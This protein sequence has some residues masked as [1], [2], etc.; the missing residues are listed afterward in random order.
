M[1]EVVARWPE[2]RVA[3]PV[4]GG[5]DSRLLLGLL[6]ERRRPDVFAIT[7]NNDDGLDR[8]E[9]FAAGVAAHLGVPHETGTGEMD[10]WW[11]DASWFALRTD[12]QIV[13]NPWLVPLTPRLKGQSALVADGLGLDVLAEAANHFI[14][15]AAI[16]A[17]GGQEGPPE[18]WRTLVARVAALPYRPVLTRALNATARRQLLRDSERFEGHPSRL[19]LT[20]WR[21]RT[22]RGIS[23]NPDAALG[24]ELPIATP[25]PDDSVAR[26]LL[27]ASPKAK[28]GGRM[29]RALYAAL[30]PALGALPSTNTP[31][32]PP[33]PRDLPMRRR[34][35][36]AARG[37][38]ELLLDS[39]LT[40]YLHRKEV[41]RL[42]R[43]ERGR[44]P[45][46]P[47]GGLPP[48]YFT[49]WHRRYRS[50]LREVDP[51]DLLA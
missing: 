2:G 49:L 28:F 31:G 3:C 46:M 7:I 35:P 15:R 40:P 11:A 42:T 9:R 13:L 26:A 22:V 18:L 4:S 47:M 38:A 10:A 16:D 51:A 27:S 17:G 25:F 41:R 33:E 48:A 23:L 45:R 20:H 43:E 21:S 14:S 30:D 5:W 39:P 24:S 29:Y 37:F 44:R 50:R 1:R 36:Q 19:L 12:Y 8:E 32:L 6:A 34:Q